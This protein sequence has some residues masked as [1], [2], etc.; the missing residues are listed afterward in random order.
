MIPSE[1]ID[2]LRGAAEAFP[3]GTASIRPSRNAPVMVETGALA[4]IFPEDLVAACEAV[5]PLRRTR[6]VRELRDGAAA[7]VAAKELAGD[8][9]P[10]TVLVKADDL[11]HLLDLLP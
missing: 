3:R 8:D 1:A 2:R 5:H 10:I 4:T 7:A 11:Y 6:K 9:T